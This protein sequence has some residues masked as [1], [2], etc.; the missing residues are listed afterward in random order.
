LAQNRA[1]AVANY[2]REQMPGISIITLNGGTL[3]GDP[4][5]WPT[6]RRA[7][8]FI[9]TL[10]PGVMIVPSSDGAGDQSG[11]GDT[12]GL[13]T[14]P[15]SDVDHALSI[16]FEINGGTLVDS[17]GDGSDMG[18]FAALDTFASNAQLA[19]ADFIRFRGFSLA[20]EDL[21][22]NPTL[23]VTRANAAAVY[24]LPKIPRLSED[25]FELQ[26][27][28]TLSGGGDDPFSRLGRVDIAIIAED[29]TPQSVSGGQHG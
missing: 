29:V 20:E 9:G 21:A 6:F 10:L 5:E 7:D 13:P 18:Q 22:G 14:F 28:G 26:D 12:S 17:V 8:F 19:R 15:G 25:G 23:A 4:Q 16:F 11:T 3:A 2:L 27:G 1:N 24:L